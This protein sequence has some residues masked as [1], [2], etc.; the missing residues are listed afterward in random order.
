M[1]E[2]QFGSAEQPPQPSVCKN[3]PETVAYVRC[4]RCGEPICAQCMNEAVVGV[5]CPQCVKAGAKAV[6][7]P[8]TI[9]GARQVQGRPYVTYTLIG[10][11]AVVW[12]LQLTVGWQAF[13]SWFVFAPF[14]GVEEP[15]RFLTASFLHSQTALY[16]I[17]FN[18]FALYSVGTQFEYILGRWH[19]LTLY[20]LSAFGGSVAVLLLAQPGADSW[21][22][23]VLGASGAIFG[24]FG[25]LIPY[26]RSIGS[27]LRGLAG[28]FAINLAIPFLVPQVS[29]QG[30]LGGLVVGVL[31]GYL[32]M[33]APRDKRLLV[34]I[35]GSV[36]VALALVGLAVL[37]YSQ[38]DPALY[39]F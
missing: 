36:V 32:F 7:A 30:H 9:T 1:S 37:K 38:V 25:A 22:T 12:L 28:L 26:Y 29:W 19:Y 39:L 14:L 13:S 34:S 4:Q 2:P 33:W 11:N 24:L 6:R 35:G 15:W 23:P 21:F 16:H 5:Q 18:M 17:L 20:L 27:D 8:R 31:V 10:A 3:H